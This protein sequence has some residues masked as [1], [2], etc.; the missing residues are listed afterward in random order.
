MQDS[1]DKVTTCSKQHYLAGIKGALQKTDPSLR[2]AFEKA[3]HKTKNKTDYEEALWALADRHETKR[4][5]KEIYDRSYKRIIGERK[6]RRPLEREKF[7]ER[8]LILRSE[9]HGRIVVGHGS[10]WFSFRENVMRGYVRLQ[11]EHQ[12]V[13]LHPEMA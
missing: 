3:T 8:L 11:A 2:L 12:G 6:G 13:F 1:P 9:A 7:N 4:Q 5:V 10:G